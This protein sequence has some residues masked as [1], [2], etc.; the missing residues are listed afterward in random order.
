M[1]GAIGP[2]IKLT[3]SFVRFIHQLSGLYLLHLKSFV[4]CL[5]ALTEYFVDIPLIKDA[6]YCQHKNRE[7]KRGPV[8]TYIFF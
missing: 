4:Y 2:S 3:V 8:Y 7:A 5:E 1:H 6:F